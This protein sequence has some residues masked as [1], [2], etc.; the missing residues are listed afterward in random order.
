MTRPKRCVCPA[1]YTN[2]RLS[3]KILMACSP[4]AVKI[5]SES[6]TYPPIYGGFGTKS[7]FRYPGVVANEPNET[8]SLRFFTLKVGFAVKIL[9]EGFGRVVRMPGYQESCTWNG[10]CQKPDHSASCRLWHFDNPFPHSGRSLERG[11]RSTFSE[12]VTSERG[13][14]PKKD[15]KGQ[16]STSE[17]NHPGCSTDSELAG[18]GEAT[19]YRK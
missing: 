17:L 13:Q 14:T 8:T 19:R 10:I 6:L 5:L 9:S 15:G 2:C 7:R 11:T 1:E 12:G 3:L 4:V 18:T 16:R